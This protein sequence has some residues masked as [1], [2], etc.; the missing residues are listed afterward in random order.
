[1]KQFQVQLA[2]YLRKEIPL[3][4]VEQALVA[5]LQDN[6]ASVAQIDEL[7]TRLFRSSQLPARDL[8]ALKKHMPASDSVPSQPQSPSPPTQMP[9]ASAQPPVTPPTAAPPAPPASAEPPAPAPVPPPAT[10]P[11]ADAGES[12]ILDIVGGGPS[13]PGS[14][15][16]SD[17]N[18]PPDPPADAGDSSILDIVGKGSPAPS[19]GP[20]STENPPSTPPAE[21]A[22]DSGDASILDIVGGGPSESAST[23]EEPPAT[24]SKPDVT[25]PAAASQPPA[26]EGATASAP[27][28]PAMPESSDIL[29]VLGA[30]GADDDAPSVADAD[31]EPDPSADR[32]VFRSPT[33]DSDRPEVSDDKTVFKQAA[34]PR[35]PKGGHSAPSHTGHSHSH[36]MPT[37][38]T[39]HSRPTG[40]YTGTGVGTGSSWTDISRLADAPARVM[41]SGVVLKDKYVLENVIGR[42]GMGVVFKARDL[43][44]E[45]AQ[46]RNP[47]VA[48]KIL[49]DEFRRHPESVVAL[50]RE[51]RKAQDLAH[52]NIVN[53]FDFDRDGATVYMVMELLEGQSLDRITKG[54]SFDGLPVDEA[55]EL[56]EGL[57]LALSYAHGKG[58]VHSD[59]K[60]GN[61]FVTRDDVIKVFD[62]GIAR[63][64]KIKGD[65]SGEET[66]FDP[67]ELGALTPAYAS[68]EML[69]GDEP[70]ARDDIY[71]LA[72]VA[73]ELLAG[74]HPFGKLSADKARDK[75]LKPEAIKGVSRRQ[76]R[77]LQ[78]GLAFARADRSASVDEFIEDL[79]PRTIN[80]TPIAIGVA[81]ALAAVAVGVAVV[82][83]MIANSRIDRMVTDITVPGSDIPGLLG[84]VELMDEAQRNAVFANGEVEDRLIRYYIDSIEDAQDQFDYPTAEALTEDALA[85]YGDSN[86][87]NDAAEQVT[88]TK[89]QL[90]AELDQRFTENLEAFRLLES[91]EDNIVAVLDDVEKI[92]PGFYLLTDSR[93]ANAYAT[94]ADLVISDDPLLAQQLITAGLTRFPADLALAQLNDRLE[95][96]LETQD[97]EIRV[98]QLER[99]VED[100]LGA[101]ETLADVGIIE[102]DLRSLLA[103]DP[104]NATAARARAFAEELV[105]AGVQAAFAQRNWPAAGRVVDEFSSVLTSEYRASVERRIADEERLYNEQVGTVYASL[106]EAT[107]SGDFASAEQ[108]LGEL[109]S[110]GADASTMAEA[111]Q[112]ITDGYLSLARSQR[113]GAEFDAARATVA[114]GQRFDA[115]FAGWNTELANIAQAETRQRE[116]EQESARQERLANIQRLES[117]I[118]EAL[119]DQQF[120]IAAA[121]ATLASIDEL[122]NLDP[123]NSRAD[124]SEVASKLAVEVLTIGTQDVRL[125]DA[126]EL[127]ASA[128]ALLPGEQSLRAAREKIEGRQLELRQRLAMEEA[129][130]ARNELESLVASPRFDVEWDSRL[131]QL[132]QG[133]EPL[134]E[135]ADFAASQRT[136]VAN[137]Y[138]Q[139]AESV[140]AENRY[141]RAQQLLDASEWFDQ[142]SNFAA[143]AGRVR[144]AR[145]AFAVESRER[146]RLASIEGFKNTFLTS[147]RAER[148]VE[149]KDALGKLTSLVPGNDPFLTNEAPNAIADTYQKLARRALEENRFDTA[150]NLAREGLKEVAGRSDL[151][152]LLADVRVQRLAVNDEAL[153]RLLREASP[154]DVNEPQRLLVAIRDDSG[155]EYSDFLDGYKNLAK[156]RAGSSRT[157]CDELVRWYTGIFGTFETPARQSPACSSSLGGYGRRARGRCFDYLPDSTTE[158]PRL[159]V[160]P[161]G[162]AVS[163]PF[164]ISQ[165]EVSVSDWNAYCRI[166]GTCAPLGGRDDS[167]PVTDLSVSDILAYTDWLSGSTNQTYRLPTQAE[168]LLAASAEN[169]NKIS[170]NCR[171]P[172]AGLGDSLLD[173]NWGTMNDYGLKNYVGNAEEVVT[174][175]PGSYEIRGGAYRDSLGLCEVGLARPHSGNASETVGFRLVRELDGDA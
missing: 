10:P 116:G 138:V 104:G 29:D 67:G 102:T 75:Q 63:A 53:V 160:V 49:N 44:R 108:R 62:F 128:E 167:L 82:P 31:D 46:D 27:D 173:A 120:G 20:G 135:F 65:L 126:L 110:Q 121:E 131:R 77:G 3:Q 5:E 30:P 105:E 57:G 25:P 17:D 141:D 124:K 18:T 48:V 111:R 98:A 39:G 134:P 26:A 96:I 73:Y 28:G 66:V 93:L 148:I 19:P 133:F 162:G 163:Q 41:E 42:G 37:G 161:A 38:A 125:D 54:A 1:M 68:L 90:L 14:E 89:Q 70:D 51:T 100:G 165:L 145:E 71:A 91:D 149:A 123:G 33:S 35:P 56:I 114:A 174:L 34:P 107:Q 45:E 80:K 61:C 94:R 76:W 150:I 103:L 99:S 95:T 113:G 52:P 97:R 127:V 78:K 50:Q 122:A 11:S 152:D 118:D 7:L 153:Q 22:P 2:R 87:L 106:I 72:C 137:L 21:P 171:N 169:S 132:I 112:V 144:E 32:T 136:A 117:A 164:A 15:P 58:V 142:A 139:Q 81:A 23:D 88:E 85:L 151:Q 59:F 16:V 55:F 60:P 43:R 155:A 6:P 130:N 86:R 115:A 69:E 147:L 129:Q 146:Q 159:V 166:S 79:R 158:G 74:K 119:R 9:P 168:W 8:I 157:G 12:S 47:F 24:P 154:G 13:A 156:E 101:I 83:D 109:D 84:E 170:P 4:P 40:A 92:D 172:Q 36:S 143:V 140:L 64:A 175:G